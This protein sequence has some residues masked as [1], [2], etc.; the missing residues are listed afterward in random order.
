MD[1]EKINKINK[2]GSSLMGSVMAIILVIGIFSGLFLFYTDQLDKNIATIDNKYNQTYKDLL[3]VQSNLD[4][5]VDNIKTA[6]DDVREAE[7]GILAAING[8]KGLG[9]AMLLLLG[10][11]SDSID[12]TEALLLSTD[13][14]PSWI[15][16]LIVVALIALIVFIVIDVLLGRKPLVN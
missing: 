15:Q 6:A 14:I 3:E 1:Y 7:S 10:F 12:T 2:N 16:S 9:Q 13:V 5:R 8:F 4:T 11:T